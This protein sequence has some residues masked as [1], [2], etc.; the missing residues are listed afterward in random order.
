M[1]LWPIIPKIMLAYRAQAYYTLDP[2]HMRIMGHALRIIGIHFLGI[3]I[4]DILGI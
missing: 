3:I 2:K 1:L 4:G